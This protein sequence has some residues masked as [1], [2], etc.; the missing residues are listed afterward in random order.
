MDT[1]EPRDDECPDID[2]ATKKKLAKH[3][4]DEVLR[5]ANYFLYN[6]KGFSVEILKMERPTYAEIAET[7]RKAARAIIAFMD[8]FDPMMGQKAHEYCELMSKIGVAI[9]NCDQ[10]ALHRWLSELERKPGV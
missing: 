4:Y 3:L 7:I 8:D 9:D 10:V 5:T 6:C 2:E 1:T